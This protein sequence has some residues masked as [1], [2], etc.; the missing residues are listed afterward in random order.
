MTTLKFTKTQAY[1]M[2]HGYLYAWE[3]EN[4]SFVKND[5]KDW[6]VIKDGKFKFSV[7]TRKVAKAY[8]LGAIK[9]GI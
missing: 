5:T 3:L 1:D 4:Y 7:T 9:M 2:G 6:W 8:I